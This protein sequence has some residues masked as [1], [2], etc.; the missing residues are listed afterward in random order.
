MSTQNITAIDISLIDIS[1]TNPR[2]VF[3]QKSLKELSVS[4]ATN[5]V[6]Q[7]ILL[8]PKGK[9]YELICGERRFKAS[10]IA[11]QKTIP[12][13]VREVT[14][15]Q[16]FEMQIIENL[17][18]ENVHPLHEAEAFKKMLEIKTNTTKTIADKVA[19][20]ES[21]IIQRLQLN[22]L[23]AKW[24]THFLKEEAITISHAL[25]ISK[26]TKEVQK[27]LLD[28]AIDFH[29]MK[30]V[31]ALESYINNNV[32]RVLDKAIF[33][34]L[35]KVLVKKAGSCTDCAKRSGYN[36]L[37][38]ADVEKDDTCFDKACFALKTQVQALN[39]VTD[40]IEN[41][42]PI[43]LLRTEY[44][45][46]DKIERLIN[47]HK[48]ATY[49]QYNDFYNTYDDAK[50]GRVEAVWING[51][52]LGKKVYV[53]LLKKESSS[54]G[55]KMADLAP[56]EQISRIQEREVRSKE[57]DAEKEQANVMA[58]LEES[59]E[60]KEVGFHKPCLIDKA[61][62][63]MILINSLDWSVRQRVFKNIKFKDFKGNETKATI[64][65]SLLAISEQDMA[66]II[67]QSYFAKFHSSKPTWNDA[68]LLRLFADN[69]KT[70]DVTKVENEQKEI[71]KKRNARQKERIDKLK[72]QVK[73]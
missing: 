10:E 65:K 34:P 36:T 19:K 29:G 26:H 60:L 1:S 58:L 48:M 15:E 14:D 39:T 8:R 50:K 18:R 46:P 13:Y 33:N 72:K 57:L 17:E 61:I 52:N 63:R 7:P 67:R 66:Y 24:K 37:L 35:D 27:D 59:K 40:V 68:K 62:S 25:I 30:S 5:G 54:G 51:N 44:T 23:I 49:R 22:N 11:K 43:L 4:I 3:N 21:Y 56:K 64:L 16:A 41:S 6:L 9:R 32:L 42:K 73:K 69:C 31:K 28:S 20:S 45:L 12:G 38:F 53:E 71:R 2:K 47:G 55:K 70:V